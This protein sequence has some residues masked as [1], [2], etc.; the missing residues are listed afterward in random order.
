MTKTITRNDLIRFIYNET[1]AVETTAIQQ[2]L[3]FDNILMD[4][5]LELLDTKE[6]IES[7]NLVPSQKTIDRILAYSKSLSSYSIEH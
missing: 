4:W 2:A 7:I 1:T 5:Y 3:L 6:S